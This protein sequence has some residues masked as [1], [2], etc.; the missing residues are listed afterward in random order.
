MSNAA[1]EK[2]FQYLE[3]NKGRFQGELFDLLKIPSISAQ[4]DHAGDVRK[5]AEWVCQ[6]CK[7]AGLSAEIVETA[8]WPAV[9]AQGEQIPG[10]RR[11]ASTANTTQPEEISSSAYRSIRTDVKDGMIVCRGSADDKARCFA[12]SWRR[13]LD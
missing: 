11:C 1:I 10:R 3:S 7:A 5:A 12:P 4:K 2:T 6:R 9:F 8:G 13:K